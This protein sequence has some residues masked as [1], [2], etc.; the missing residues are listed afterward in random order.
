MT[1]R[2]A[3]FKKNDEYRIGDVHIKGY[4]RVSSWIYIAGNRN[5]IP[6]KN[7]NEAEYYIRTGALMPLKKDETLMQKAQPSVKKDEE[8]IVS[9]PQD[10][11]GIRFEKEIENTE[12][13]KRGRKKK[14]L[15]SE[16]E[17]SYSE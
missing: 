9:A 2:Y 4:G 11:I 1:T 16:K 10:S 15:E 5:D 17:T 12:I 14:V 6:F 7:Q 13:K 3:V 8:N